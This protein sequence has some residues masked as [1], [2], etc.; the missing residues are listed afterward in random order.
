MEE[1]GGVGDE[2]VG[3]PEGGGGVE[4]DAVL[5]LEGGSEPSVEDS[6]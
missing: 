5:V 3:C 1:S 4:G 6:D 2:E